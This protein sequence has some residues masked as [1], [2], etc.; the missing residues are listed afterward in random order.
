VALDPT[1]ASAH[2]ALADALAESGAAQEAELH[3]RLV[4]ALD[5]DDARAR[6]GLAALGAP[7]AGPG[8][9]R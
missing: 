8:Q 7:P 4:L 6:S 5:P 9:G 2:R 1:S 3:Y